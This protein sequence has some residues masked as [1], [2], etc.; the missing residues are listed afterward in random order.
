MGENKTVAQGLVSRLV[1][2]GSRPIG[3]YITLC[4]KCQTTS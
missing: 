2:V 3:S 4:C 1:M